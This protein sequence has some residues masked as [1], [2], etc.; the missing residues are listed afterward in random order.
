MQVEPSVI[1]KKLNI[2]NSIT[3]R[4]IA[5]SEGIVSSEQDVGSM[6]DSLSLVDEII[7]VRIAHQRQL[8]LTLL[9]VLYHSAFIN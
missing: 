9:Q 6:I 7:N 4:L 2:I 8:A 3:Q 5:I 1:E